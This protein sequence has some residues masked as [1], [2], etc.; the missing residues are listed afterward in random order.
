MKIGLIDLITTF[1]HAT[2]HKVTAIYGAP[3]LG[4]SLIQSKKVR[5]GGRRRCG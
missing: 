4:C 2:K 3:G 1:E 5:Q